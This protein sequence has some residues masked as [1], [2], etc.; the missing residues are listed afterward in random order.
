MP[1]VI[2]AYTSDRAYNY[3]FFNDLNF[4]IINNFKHLKSLKTPDV[5]L[6]NRSTIFHL[7]ITN[8]PSKSGSNNT[9]THSTS[10]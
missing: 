10:Q 7:K 4:L 1:L 8:E 3:T 6:L 5:I 2:C 9:A